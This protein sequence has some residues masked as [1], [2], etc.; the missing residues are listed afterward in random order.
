MMNRPSQSVLR[1]CLSLPALLLWMSS[2][3]CQAQPVAASVSREPAE[4]HT[5]AFV[6]GMER[7]GRHHEI[8]TAEAGALLISELS[9]TTCHASDNALLQPKRGPQLEAVGSRVNRGWLQDFLLDPQTFRPGTTMPS[10]LHGLPEP[11]RRRKAQALTAFLAS[12]QQPFPELKATGVNPVPAEFWDRGQVDSGKSLFHQTGCVACHAPD[13]DYEIVPMKP[14]PFDEMLE[15]LEP[16]ELA[17]MGLSGAAR[18]VAS[19]PLPSLRA[20]YSNQSL[21]FFLLNPTEVRP[22]AR[23][24]H[25]GLSA[26]EA[27]DLAAYL[28][29]RDAN[30]IAGTEQSTSNSQPPAGS[31]DLVNEGRRLFFTTGCS[32]CHSVQGLKQT[33]Q[34]LQ[35]HTSWTDKTAPLNQ[36]TRSFAEQCGGNGSA[37]QPAFHLDAVQIAAVED[38]LRLLRS[39]DSDSAVFSS[40]PAEFLML[41]LNCYGCH[42]RNTKGGIGRYRRPYFETIGH[43]D[44]GDEGRFPPTLTGVGSKL[45]TAWMTGVLSGK[46]RVRAHLTIRMPQYSGALQK[47]LPDA[48]VNS[49]LPQKKPVP[50]STVFPNASRSDLKEAG[51][52]LMDAGCVQCHSFRGEFLPGTVGVDL[53]G[54]SQRVHPEW[55]RQFLADPAALK[56]GT[57]MPTFFPNGKSSHQ[58]ILGG[59]MGLQIEAMWSYLRDLDKQP[60]PEKIVAARNQDYELKPTDHPI[61]LRTFMPVAGTHAI[62]IGF[63]QGVHYAFDA[64]GLFPAVAWRHRFLDAEGTWF[65]RF[66]PPAAP[67]GDETVVLPSGVVLAVTED[68]ATVPKPWPQAAEENGY[69]FLGYRLEKDTRIPVLRYRVSEF[70]VEDRITPNDSGGLEREILITD[71]GTAGEKDGR[72]RRMLWLRPAHGKTLLPTAP[73]GVTNSTGLTVTIDQSL[74]TSGN[75]AVSEMADGQQWIVQVPLPTDDSSPEHSTRI[76]ITYSWSHSQS[77]K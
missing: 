5:S 69:R 75:S 71:Q 64:D 22:A 56:R 1:I 77:D 52:R 61:M 40:G 27:A 26:V 2:G 3:R 50:E 38:A 67:L 54:T 31:A 49:D 46:S 29:D 32:Q 70:R 60:L 65:V 23:M 41:Q 28:R 14:S 62:A 8:S 15:T 36:L 19:V 51:R 76:H 59:D 58:D 37:Q 9:C 35:F 12:L 72:K 33:A 73:N 18:R 55:F 4:A 25:F 6:S 16:D 68:S 66:A 43:V 63:P 13:D 45:T 48:F 7:F 10:V 34:E 74:I 20:K 39:P 21:T 30:D 53:A 57:R 44:I 24:P 47:Q 11:E 42:D 17:Q